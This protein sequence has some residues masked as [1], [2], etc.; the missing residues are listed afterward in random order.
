MVMAVG[1]QLA[2]EPVHGGKGSLSHVEVV[3]LT[4]DSD[5]DDAQD[6]ALVNGVVQPATNGAASKAHFP[7]IPGESHGGEEAAREE[8]GSEEEEGDETW[9]TDSFYEDYIEESG[10]IEQTGTGK[11]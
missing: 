9:E 8:E 7:Q 3:D 10:S 5:V 6:T 11:F 1:G 2:G 4:S